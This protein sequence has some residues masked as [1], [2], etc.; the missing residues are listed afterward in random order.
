MIQEWHCFGKYC[1][2]S[3]KLFEKSFKT[4]GCKIISVPTK[5]SNVSETH[6]VFLF[7]AKAGKIR[8]Y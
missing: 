3:E 2:N 8:F 1:G 7:S 6:N 4:L 5:L